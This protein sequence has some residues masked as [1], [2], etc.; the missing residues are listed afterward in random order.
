MTKELDATGYFFH[1]HPEKCDPE[2]FWGQVKRTINGEPVDQA[3]IDLIVEGVAEGIDIQSSDYIYDM[4]C[5]NGALS[6][7]LF[8]R[9]EGGVGVDF[10]D[11]LINVANKHFK[12][13]GR[14]EY[15]LD[16]VL[17]FAKTGNERVTKMFCFG[18]FQY[19]PFDGV[20]GLLSSLY[21]QF[22][23]LQR[24]FLGNIP[25]RGLSQKFFEER[26]FI[27]DSLEDPTSAIGYW[28]E[29]E[30][31]RSMV[32]TAGWQAEF[33][34]LPEEFYASHYRFNAILTR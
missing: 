33:T 2:D 4:C 21:K 23:N 17:A 9:C 26:D 22:P 6:H 1:D 25:D 15:L 20:Q 14:D 29:R 24:C 11:F 30:A 16:D 12:V 7:Y 31:L 19:L 5:G 27:P 32:E 8:E 13:D 28:W 18:S 3:Q 34:Q 10:S